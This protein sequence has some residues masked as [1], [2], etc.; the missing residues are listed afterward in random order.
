MRGIKVPQSVIKSNLKHAPLTI[1]LYLLLKQKESVADF[2]YAQ[3]GEA[4]ELSAK[5]VFNGVK[6][7]VS[8][9]LITA[10]HKKRSGRIVAMLFTIAPQPRQKWVWVEGKLFDLHLSASELKVYLYLKCRANQSSRAWPSLSTVSRDTGLAEET[11]RRAVKRLKAASLLHR[12]RNW[13][14]CGSRANNHYVTFNCMQREQVMIALRKKKARTRKIRRRLI[15]KINSFTRSAYHF[16][17]QKST[18]QLELLRC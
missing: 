4:L 8:R 16:M 3:L 11:I 14:E 1:Y 6:E 18:S 15:R 5:T 10:E 12:I 2:T 9:G 13:K 7:L 17:N